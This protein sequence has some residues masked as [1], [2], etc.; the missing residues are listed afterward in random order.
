MSSM[1]PKLVFKLL[2]VPVLF[3]LASCY[4]ASISCYFHMPIV[5]LLTFRLECFEGFPTSNRVLLVFIYVG[6]SFS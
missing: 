3:G 4:A 1:M 2:K 6:F 5:A